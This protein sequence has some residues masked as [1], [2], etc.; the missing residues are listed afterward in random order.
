M[1]KATKWVVGTAGVI[2][3]LVLLN[4]NRL[5]RFSQ[6]FVMSVSVDVLPSTK[7]PVLNLGLTVLFKNP[8]DATLVV[9]HPT[10]YFYDSNPDVVPR[11]DPFLT[12]TVEGKTYT[13]TANSQSKV[14]PVVLPVSITNLGLVVRL[15]TMLYQFFR[16]PADWKRTLYYQSSTQI[17]GT[18]PY[19]TPTQVFTLHSLSYYKTLWASGHAPVAPAL[20]GIAGLP[21]APARPR[22]TR[23]HL[24]VPRRRTG[25]R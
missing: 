24:T 4:L 12:S 25:R 8:T 3:G 11:P 22:R 10:V 13:I 7:F 14:G 16:Q 9:K 17:N 20:H 5:A 15:A 2:G 1:D 23:N 6:K 19:Q 21:A 18:V